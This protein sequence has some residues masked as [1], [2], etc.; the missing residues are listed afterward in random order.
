MYFHTSRILKFCGLV[1]VCVLPMDYVPSPSMVDL[2]VLKCT[3]LPGVSH[4]EVSI[5]VLTWENMFSSLRPTSLYLVAVIMEGDDG[6]IIHSFSHCLLLLLPI[7]GS[8]YLHT[9]D[10]YL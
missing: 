1:V 4:S 7:I 9:T 3:V 5:P 2:V 8:S 6:A 10:Y